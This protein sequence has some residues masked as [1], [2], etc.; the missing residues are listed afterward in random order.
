MKLANV[1]PQKLNKLKRIS[2]SSFGKL[3]HCA[4]QVVFSANK[5]PQL[6]PNHPN[7]KLGLLLHKIVELCIKGEI[8]DGKSFE[9]IWNEK[10]KSIHKEMLSNELDKNFVP[11]SKSAN[12][13]SVKKRLCHNFVKEI[14]AQK[15]T[16][17]TR[18]SKLRGAEKWVESKDKLVGGVIDEV[19]QSPNGTHIIDL[20]TGNIFDDL[21]SSNQEIKTEYQ[22]QMKLY[23]ALYFERVG[24][25]PNKLLIKTL[26]GQEYEI[27]FDNKECLELLTKAKGKFNEINNIIEGESDWNI[28]ANPSLDAC[29]YCRFRPICLSYWQTK[30]SN[31]WDTTDVSGKVTDI[32]ELNNGLRISLKNNDEMIYVRGLNADKHKELIDSQ[33][34]LVRILNLKPDS[35]KNYYCESRFTTSFEV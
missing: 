28:L 16:S 31:S 34:K 10:I 35:S 5:I 3:N 17:S 15:T 32:V 19:R 25:F 7:A 12:N 24:S 29:K 8:F 22:L 9:D 1:I 11:L 20:K 26:E 6:L 14:G 4:L 23:A 13:F 2:P 27:P 18:K 30:E 21:S 33:G